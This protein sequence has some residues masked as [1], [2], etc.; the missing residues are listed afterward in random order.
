MYKI[1]LKKNN[2]IFIKKSPDFLEILST[3]NEYVW[4]KY[5]ISYLKWIFIEVGKR[6]DFESTES[7]DDLL[8][9]R[10]RFVGWS[11]YGFPLFLTISTVLQVKYLVLKIF[12]RSRN[13]DVATWNSIVAT[14]KWTQH[15]CTLLA[16]NIVVATFPKMLF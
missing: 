9:C 15:D 4:I 13:K 5:Y 14:R 6:K 11:Y 8:S 3:K 1:R 7:V 16:R 10:P 12:Y 2:F